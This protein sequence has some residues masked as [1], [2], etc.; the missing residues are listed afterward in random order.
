MS[1]V[2]RV[3]GLPEVRVKIYAANERRMGI[4]L[5]FSSDTRAATVPV[6]KELGVLRSRVQ[7][8]ICCSRRTFP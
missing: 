3:G 1:G 4:K 8:Q 2:W 6:I 7:L 5:E